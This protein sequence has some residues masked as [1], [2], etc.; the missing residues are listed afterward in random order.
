[1]AQIVLAGRVD[2]QRGERTQHLGLPFVHVGL[3]IVPAAE[4]F[5]PSAPLNMHTKCKANVHVIDAR[6]SRMALV[7]L[8]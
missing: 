6:I 2:F 3:E 7:S 1:M 8:H 5:R 4:Q